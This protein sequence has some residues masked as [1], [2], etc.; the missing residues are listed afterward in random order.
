M[1]SKVRLRRRCYRGHEK[2]RY[3]STLKS[4]AR[5]KSEWVAPCIFRE[6]YS[7]F[8]GG[9][10]PCQIEEAQVLIRHPVNAHQNL[11]MFRNGGAAGYVSD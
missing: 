5:G 2:H 9:L 8:V 6:L 7:D 4:V 1:Q 10:E 11:K 3:W